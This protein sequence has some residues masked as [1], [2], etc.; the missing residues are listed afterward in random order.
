MQ[1]SHFGEFQPH[2]SQFDHGDGFASVLLDMIGY[3]HVQL[4]P[5]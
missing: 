1:L 5:Q 3:E 4:S 2:G